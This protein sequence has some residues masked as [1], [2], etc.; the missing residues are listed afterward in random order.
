MADEWGVQGVCRVKKKSNKAASFCSLGLGVRKGWRDKVH[1]ELSTHMTICFVLI[2]SAKLTIAFPRRIR[3]GH[4]RTR[5]LSINLQQLRRNSKQPTCMQYHR[6]LLEMDQMP[7]SLSDA[8][9]QNKSFA[10]AVGCQWGE[11][12]KTLMPMPSSKWRGRPTKLHWPRDKA[13]RSVEHRQTG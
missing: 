5:L 9:W 11:D 2:F 10:M 7:S 12:I 8:L 1:V 3:L 4:V 6:R 13:R